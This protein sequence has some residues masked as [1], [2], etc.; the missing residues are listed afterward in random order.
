MLSGMYLL[1]TTW[2]QTMATEACRNR[3]TPRFGHRARLLHVDLNALEL[4][5]SCLVTSL[6][7]H[8][9]KGLLQDFGSLQERKR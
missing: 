5:F 9:G 7:I 3:P 6:Y 1:S 2:H 4:P 8:Y